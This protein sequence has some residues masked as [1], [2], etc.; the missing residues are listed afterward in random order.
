MKSSLES[1][2]NPTR[3]VFVQSMRT[4]VVAFAAIGKGV[5]ARRTFFFERDQR[6]LLRLQRAQTQHQTSKQ[7]LVRFSM[8]GDFGPEEAYRFW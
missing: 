7:A 4:C 1:K 3:L 6:K 8:F 5:Q 2:R